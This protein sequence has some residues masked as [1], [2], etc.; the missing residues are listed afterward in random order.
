[1]EVLS[2][3]ISIIELILQFFQILYSHGTRG[4]KTICALNVGHIPET[5]C[6]A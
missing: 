6:G 2:E 5:K 3:T 4:L 1:M